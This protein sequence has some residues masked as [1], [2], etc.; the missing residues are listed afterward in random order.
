MKELTRRAFIK[1]T[2]GA[3]GM[4]AMGIS[5]ARPESA[6][7]PFGGGEL[8][9]SVSFLDGK[10][11]LQMGDGLDARFHTD[12]A[13]LGSATLITPNEHFFVRTRCSDLID[14][15]KSWKIAVGGLVERP[16]E[17][18]LD[19]LKPSIKPMGAVLLE[20][21]GNQRRPFGLMSAARWSGIPLA[22]VLQRLSIKPE[23]T[24]VLVSG[25]D[26]YSIKPH[27]SIP[28]ASWVFSF[29]D[30][31]K[32][33]A[34]LATE[35]NGEALSRDHGFPLR[36]VVP[37]WFS[38]VD[39]KW[40]NKIV[41]VDDSQKATGQMLEFASRINQ[42]GTPRLASDFDPALIDQAALP[43]RIE[44]WRVS[45]QLVYRVVGLL[46]GGERASDKLMIRFGRDED[47]VPL[48]MPYV[49]ESNNTWT[50]WSHAWKPARMGFY[51]I[52]M[53]IDDASIRTWRLDRGL[54]RRRIYIKQV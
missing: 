10:E 43:V 3:G 22:T 35:M 7:D 15:D 1:S 2:L 41:L 9:G 50:L 37:R 8:L 52:T 12:L 48:N 21:A 24:R 46:W 54:H 42:Q 28:G 33:G 29:A 39:I 26:E 19:E 34:F 51:D 44:K 14:F 32:Y 16:V 47:P 13:T 18:D 45:D 53:H 49:Q 6:P 27:S 23:A 30:I 20:C 40:V 38:C 25:F 31:E 36:L 5:C 17:L 4:L 11:P